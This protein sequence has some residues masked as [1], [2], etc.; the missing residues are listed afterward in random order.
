MP[1]QRIAGMRDVLIHEYFVV[2]LNL[3]WRTVQRDL[4]SLKT[5]M[6]E[7]LRQN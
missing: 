5:R 7:V 1:W 6:E 2:D 4:P 3:T